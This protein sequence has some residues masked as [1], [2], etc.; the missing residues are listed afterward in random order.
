VSSDTLCVIPA[1]SGSVRIRHKNLMEV[2]GRTLLER[3][4]ATALEAVEQVVVSTDDEHYAAIARRA[5]A[6]VP[7]LRPAHLAGPWSSTED[8]VRHVLTDWMPAEVVCVMQTTSPFTTAEDV[9]AVLAALHRRPG[10][11]SAFTAR[12]I[13]PMACFAFAADGDEPALPLAPGLLTR[14]TQDL[15]ELVVPT[16]GVYAAHAGHLLAGGSLVDAPAA[17]TVVDERRALDIDDPAD[18]ERAR[19]C[20]EAG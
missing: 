8:V 11:R 16:G 19:R 9:R 15:P 3:A 13:D 20:A 12:R 7:E 10:T 2:G 18:L 6:S 1:R 5:G 17:F 4:V 14:R